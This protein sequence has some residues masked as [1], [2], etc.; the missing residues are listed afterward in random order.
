MTVLHGICSR[1]WE[2]ASSLAAS[3][4]TKI[5]SGGGTVQ[6]ALALF[7]VR[8]IDAGPSGWRHAQQVIALR[9]CRRR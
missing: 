2:H 3:L 1:E 4:C 6:D 5:S 8:P 7:G 9:L